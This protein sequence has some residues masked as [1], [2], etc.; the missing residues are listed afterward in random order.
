MRRVLCSCSLR[1]VLVL[2]F[3][4]LPTVVS[5]HVVCRRKDYGCGIRRTD[6]ETFEQ[7]RI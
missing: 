2:I 3:S 6:T 1:V 7:D 4:S 5:F